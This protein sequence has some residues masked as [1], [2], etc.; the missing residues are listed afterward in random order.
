[1]L[2]YVSA[3][4]NGIGGN[5]GNNNKFYYVELEDSGMINTRYGRVGT[6]GTSGKKSGGQREFDKLVQSKKKK[7]YVEVPLDLDAEET[8]VSGGDDVMMIALSQI[9]SDDKSKELIKTLVQ[10]NIHNITSNTKITFNVSTGLFKTPLGIVTTEGVDEALTILNN[11]SGL[12]KDTYTA[13]EEKKIREL[14]E[15]YYSIIPTTLSNLRSFTSMLYTN[16]KLSD[17]YDICNALKQS[18]D[19][20]Q[21]EKDKKIEELKE[22]KTLPTVFNTSLVKL[23]DADEFK[24]ISDYFENSKNDMHGRTTSKAKVVNIYKINIEKDDKAYRHDLPNQMELWHG[25]K[26][27]NILSILKSGLLMPK[28]SPGAVTGYMFGQGLY[29]SNQSSKSLN[30]CDGMYWNS[31]SR[32]GN[33]LYMFVADIA[34]GNYKVPDRSTSSNPPAGYDSYWAQPGKSGIRNDEMIVFKNEQIR[35]KYLLEIEV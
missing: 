34:M 16:K 33:K 12:I 24:R 19:L 26:V 6:E 10:Q 28:Y 23:D 32:N 9:Q 1:M 22:D 7:G 13:K 4:G 18:I 2:I 20:V 25:T 8:N 30:Y 17:Q 21:T 5:T 14:S 35:L 15:K 31:S 29:F 27:A 11:L 3:E